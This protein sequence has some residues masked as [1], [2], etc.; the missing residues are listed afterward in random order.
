MRARLGVDQ[1]YIGL[2]PGALADDAAFQ[3]VA[4]PALLAD[5]AR[6]D[7]PPLEGKSGAPRDD[8]DAFQAR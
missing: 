4:N 5:L 6:I 8:K 7:R 3:K 1:L 2:D